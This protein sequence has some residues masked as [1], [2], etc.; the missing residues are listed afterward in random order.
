MVV[1]L[2]RLYS[3]Y[4]ILVGALVV[5]NDV[6]QADARGVQKGGRAEVRGC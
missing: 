2:A 5:S 3:G 6:L 4:F 1:R